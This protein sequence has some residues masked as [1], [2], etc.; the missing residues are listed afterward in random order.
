[1]FAGCENLTRVTIPDGVTSIGNNAFE[2]C[3]S[4]TDINIP[5]SVTSIG[6]SAFESCNNLTSINIPSSVTSIGESAFYNC[7]SLTSIIIPPSVTSIG[8]FAFTGCTYLT[9]DILSS[10]ISV[11]ERA[12]AD[13]RDFVIEDGC[14]LAHDGSSKDVTIPDDVTSIGEGAFMD[15]TDLI[16]I[17][18]P[19][20]VISIG[21]EA[22]KGCSNL[23]S[24][25]IP[26]GVTSISKYAF[27]NCTNLTRVTIPD[28]VT[29]IGFDAFGKCVNLTDVYYSGSE[30]QWKT[31][32]INYDEYEDLDDERQRVISLTGGKFRPNSINITIHKAPPKAG[33]SNDSL[34]NANIHCNEEDIFFSFPLT[35]SIEGTAYENRNERIEHVQI[36]DSLIL[37]ANWRSQYYW[38]VAVEVFNAKNETLGFLKADFENKL[39]IQIANS[40]DI[41][42]ATVA[43]VTPLSKR[44]KNAKYALLDVEI[45]VKQVNSSKDSEDRIRKLE[46]QREVKRLWHDCMMDG[47]SYRVRC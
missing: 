8:D 25:I 43:S 39:L 31:I 38:P 1:M 26:D 14:L 34:F 6:D 35:V 15:R 40:I 18:I 30:S 32:D 37:K 44:K 12:F 3:C 28:S 16:S 36:G 33:R 4:L 5:S 47:L 42:Q 9:R 23:I 20:S 45:S 10:V 24:V 17:S 13:T 27:S 46:K 2:G 19:P 11:G 22:F 7:S 29:G 21:D 41:L